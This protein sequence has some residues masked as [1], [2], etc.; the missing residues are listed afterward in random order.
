MHYIILKK[1]GSEG[2]YDENGKSVEKALMK[3]PINGARLSSSFGLRKHP[4]LGY[5]KLHQ[6]T[7]FAAPKGTPIM[8][9]GSCTI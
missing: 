9:S 4:I 5:N 6:G 2:H 3:T 1:K 7:D 8:A